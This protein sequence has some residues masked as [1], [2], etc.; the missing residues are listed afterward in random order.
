MCPT[1]DEGLTEGWEHR[2]HDGLQ[3]K[4]GAE[5]EAGIMSYWGRKGGAKSIRRARAQDR[6]L[7]HPRG[8]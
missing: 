4:L 1:S 8:V 2:V 6:D 3:G 5:V 7:V